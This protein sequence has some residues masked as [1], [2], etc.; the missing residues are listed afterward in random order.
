MTQPRCETCDRRI[1]GG[2]CPDGSRLPEGFCR[3][4][5]RDQREQPGRELPLGFQDTQAECSVRL[6]HRTVG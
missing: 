3:Y 1:P 4:C 6:R 5:G 2:K